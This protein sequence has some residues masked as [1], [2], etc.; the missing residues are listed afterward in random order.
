MKKPSRAR[1]LVVFGA[2]LAVAAVLLTWLV[3]SSSLDFEVV[4]RIVDTPLLATANLA[5]WLFCSIGLATLRWRTLLSA[6]GARVPWG[7]ALM[8]QL[9]GLF[10]NLVIPGNVGGDV[11]KALYVA[12]DQAPEVRGGVLLIVLVERLAGLMGLVGIASLVVAARGGALLESPAYRP[13]VSV[14]LLLGL[15]FYGGTAVALFAV[16]R[17]GARLEERLTGASK[18]ASLLRQ[19]LTAFRLVSH[20][21]RALAVAL[22]ASMAMHATS[23]AYFTLLTRTV[24]HQEVAYSEVASLFPIGLLSLLLPI[25]PAGFGVGHVVFDKLFETA[26]LTGGATIFNVFLIGQMTPCLIGVVPYLLLRSKTKLPTE[27]EAAAL[28]APAPGRGETG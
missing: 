5:C 6:V 14:V 28:A 2:K 11:I 23:M 25:S 3:R 10:F 21:P 24:G 15:G 22:V 16:R 12:R 27:E 19:L 8:L 1:G 17:Y 4:K 13:L 20:R 18:L 26:G 7:R 9:T